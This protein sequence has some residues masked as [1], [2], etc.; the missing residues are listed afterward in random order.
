M[1]IRAVPGLGT[2]ELT[3]PAT[4]GVVGS[5]LIGASIGLALSAVGVD[6]LL[7]DLDPEQVKVA[8]SMG[9]GR[10]WVGERVDHAIVA[11]P[12]HAVAGVLR[13][14]QQARLAGTYSDVSSV[15]ARP[16]I[17]AVQVGCDLTT[18]CPAHPV[19]GRERGGAISARADL[20]AERTW[21]F[22]P[23]PHT[24]R[25]AVATAVA[26]AVA[27]GAVPIGISAERHDVA[28]AAVSHVPQVVA[29]ML[30]AATGELRPGELALAGQG[31]RDTTRIADSDPQLWASIL[32]GNRGPLVAQ[33]R[34]MATGLSELADTFDTAGED[35]TLARVR[36]LIGRGNAGRALLPGKAGAPG[37]TW[38]WVSVVL[39]DRPGQLGALFTAIGRW[40]FN[41][42]DVGPFEHSL[43]APAGIVEIAVDRKFVD[44]LVE[45]LTTGGW[46][47]Y[48][49][50]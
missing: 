18:W 27:C 34:R 45:R 38:S 29:S 12:P 33:L 21:V 11:V 31:F 7:R 37:R 46:T 6:V 35:V 13:E 47:A 32:E 2:L 17:E 36:E 25:P 8:A 5:G 28:M 39:D 4:V 42:E 14:I 19:A 44:E 1:E 40:E 50:S 24:S 22:C 48:R 30:A 3:L 23:V 15:K 41:V 20:F 9:A 49:R 43:D 16:I 10:P 26:V